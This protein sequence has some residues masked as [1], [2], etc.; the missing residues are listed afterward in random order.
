MSWPAV[1]AMSQCDPNIRNLTASGGRG[2]FGREQR[3]FAD[4]GFWEVAIKIPIFK[5]EKARAYR[6]MM[7]RLRQGEEIDVAICDRNKSRGAKTEATDGDVTFAS[8]AAL[9]ATEVVLRVTGVE[10]DAGTYFCTGPYL[11]MVTEVVSNGAT[12]VFPNPLHDGEI[13]DDNLPWSDSD[14]TARNVTVK[15]MPPMRF[16]AASGT[17]ARFSNLYMRGELAD[18]NDGDLSLDLGRFGTATLTIREAL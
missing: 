13:W 14:P 1:L 6:G 8:A 7:A 3:V 2:R 18:V 10:I 11:H 9:R 15:I 17:G 12:S 5:P 16:A 4:A